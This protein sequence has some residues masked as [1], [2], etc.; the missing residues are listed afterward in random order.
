MHA[1]EAVY[2]QVNDSDGGSPEEDVVDSAWASGLP[3]VMAVCPWLGPRGCS[4]MCPRARFLGGE[5][6]VGG[7]KT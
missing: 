1:I 4:G 6:V 3:Q 5:A 7:Q 2:K